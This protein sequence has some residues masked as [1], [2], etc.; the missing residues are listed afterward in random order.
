MSDNAEPPEP[1]IGDNPTDPEATAADFRVKNSSKDTTLISELATALGMIR[2]TLPEAI[3]H[4][5]TELQGV[6]SH[7]WKALTELHEAGKHATLFSNSFA[8]GRAFS[9]SE[10][11][12]RHRQPGMVEWC[13]PRKLRGEFAIPADLRV[14][15][16]YLV[17]CKYDSK[18][19]LNSGP[20][21]LFDNR[22]KDTRRGATSWYEEVAGDAYQSYYEAVRSHFDLG[23]LPSDVT[24][25]ADPH[26]SVLAEV[27]PREL[28]LG[29]AGDQAAFCWAVSAAS[30]DR[31]K[32][33]IGS[34]A[35]ERT[36]FAM[37]L[38]R[39]PQAIYFLLGH[40]GNSSLRFKVLSRWD[41]AARYRLRDF[42]V[43]ASKA[44]Q[45]T[46]LPPRR[47]VS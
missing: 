2:K 16:V 28:P 19:L 37:S 40:S 41:W 21:K 3:A 20:A 17:S 45:P 30:V 22:L 25:L 9:T 5:P 35:Q 47:S 8:N 46:S 6:T 13:G 33:S 12:L 44:M 38:L 34:R 39:I 14:D 43:E 11:A 15:D 4:L 29:L 24:K 32:K 7:D 26:R 36:D 23:Y 42:A 31:W 27:L 18:N 1:L 10:V